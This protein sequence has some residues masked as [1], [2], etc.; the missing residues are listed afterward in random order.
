[1]YSKYK[2]TRGVIP[3]LKLCKTLL[4]CLEVLYFNYL[5]VYLNVERTWETTSVQS[6]S[7]FFFC[8]WGE[9]RTVPLPLNMNLCA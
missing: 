7:N 4:M 5:S 1:M 6:S 3:S 8:G 9:V 2:D